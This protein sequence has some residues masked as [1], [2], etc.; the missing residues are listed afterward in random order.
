M[1]TGMPSTSHVA[2]Y[3]LHFLFHS[4]GLRCCKIIIII[5]VASCMS[6]GNG[7]LPMNQHIYM[8]AMSPGDN[9]IYPCKSPRVF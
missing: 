3:V 6:F 4:L 5:N 1:L 7:A 8:Y 2:T 9:D